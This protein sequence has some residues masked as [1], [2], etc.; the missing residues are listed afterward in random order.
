[1]VL[2]GCRDPGLSRGD[3][4]LA[5]GKFQEAMGAYRTT[6]DG[7][8]AEA[9]DKEAAKEAF[10]DAWRKERRR[11][12]E[13]LAEEV[14]ALERQPLD[15]EATQLRV[16]ALRTRLGAFGDV[17]PELARLSSLLERASE[18]RWQRVESLARARKFVAADEL[19]S[20]I[21]ASPGLPPAFASRTK[22]LR[23]QA[24]AHYR[25]RSR[26]AE[27]QPLT[28]AL[29]RALAE[30]FALS[31][32]TPAKALAAAATPRV[33]LALEGPPE[34]RPVAAALD[35]A[36]APPDGTLP[37]S[38]TLSA[39]CASSAKDD[40]REESATYWVTEPAGTK[41][42]T[43]Y[44]E[45]TKCD[46][47]PFCA[48]AVVTA[49]GGTQYVV[50]QCRNE[51]RCTPTMV[52]RTREVPAFKDTPRVE[53]Y[54]HTF[55]TFEASVRG[56]LV[57][58]LDGV[59]EE[60]AALTLAT[61]AKD[62]AYDRAQGRRE[63]RDR[64]S[65]DAKL[66]TAAVLA[67][68]DEDIAKAGRRVVAKLLERR[69]DALLA[70]LSP[71]EAGSA[72]D[73]V[74]AS[75]ALLGS[76]RATALTRESD[77]L[78]RDRMLALLRGM[79]PLPRNADSPPGPTS[80]P[81]RDTPPSPASRGGYAGYESTLKAELLLG[82]LASADIPS[83]AGALKGESTF[84]VA[85]RLEGSLLGDGR[86]SGLQF[87]DS[88]SGTLG[89]GSR[90]SDDVLGPDQS[91][92]GFRLDVDYTALLGARIRQ[93]GLFA[94]AR[95]RGIF[96]FTGEINTGFAYQVPF[97]ARAEARLVK[98]LMPTLTG[99]A[100][101]LVGGEHTSVE[102]F[103]PLSKEGGVHAFGRWERI[104]ADASL[105]GYRPGF[106]DPEKLG[107]TTLLVGI[108]FGR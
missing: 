13:S 76:Q 77:G 60:R 102:L 40:V 58:R 24:R 65:F 7:D 34:C 89:L 32:I 41:L 90:T 5:E 69:G 107:F 74:V 4:H 73:E 86:P 84:M 29:Y 68:F 15:P 51:V 78:D 82:T 97:C 71:S 104:T 12:R 6:L 87:L 93:V 19:A 23:E 85:A 36:L 10:L 88:A 108:G 95:A 33:T 14:R 17:G 49:A 67:R 75:A 43:V 56:A 3:R 103:A 91:G 28:S 38:V 20:S 35:K 64:R 101:S 39:S 30:H 63:T 26:L 83:G 2:P 31:P 48:P 42:E 22:A 106:S 72:R 79:D 54:K 9:W 37:L 27:G 47:Y 80:D 50:N 57:A 21:L 94:G 62:E 11:E 99:C 81:A 44:V 66:S 8:D 96:A 16:Q 59:G 92:F 45:E 98:N 52:P 105:G 46:S 53:P 55:R 1:M 100:V 18:L 70:A 61:S 25:E